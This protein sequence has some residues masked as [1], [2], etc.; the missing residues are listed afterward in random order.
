MEASKAKYELVMGSS[1]FITLAKVF[2]LFN[3]YANRR[4]VKVGPYVVKMGH[5]ISVDEALSSIHASELGIPTPK[6]LSVFKYKTTTYIVA[7]RIKGRTLA[8]SWS[9]MTPPQREQALSDIR[10]YISLMKSDVKE[11]G[12]ITRVSGSGVFDQSISDGHQYSPFASQKEFV[13]LLLHGVDS[14]PEEA[15]LTLNKDRPIT[16]THGDLS[17][18]NIMV[19]SGVI[20]SVIDWEFSGYFPDYWELAK[21]GYPRFKRH[22][23]YL[24]FEPSFPEYKEGVEAFNELQKV[25]SPY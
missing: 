7:E 6:V 5:D 22:Q 10:R 12:S 1:R 18:H 11:S 15:K 13:S 2:A 16:F 23:W 4:V 17:A 14:L 8:H 19:R 9:S 20:V 3:L 25:R 24:L 21:L